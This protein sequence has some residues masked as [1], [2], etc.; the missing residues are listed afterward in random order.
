MT[1]LIRC[2]YAIWRKQTTWRG[3]R[4]R[5]ADDFTLSRRGG[6]TDVIGEL[7]DSGA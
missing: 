5:L 2:V 4:R 6:R 3:D 1:S 7:G